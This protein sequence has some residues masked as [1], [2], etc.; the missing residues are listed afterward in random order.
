MSEY[1]QL[2]IIVL[3]LD[4]NGQDDPL[5]IIQNIAVYDDVD[6]SEIRKSIEKAIRCI[7]DELWGGA[8]K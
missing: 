7:E 6:R 4:R 1:K 2:Q 3:A 8:R 5:T